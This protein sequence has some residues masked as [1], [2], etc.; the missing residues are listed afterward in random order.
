[1]NKLKSILLG[2]LAIL[3]YF[4]FNKF[5]ALP[6]VIFN[7]DVNQLPDIIK[8]IYS[9]IIDLLIIIV[10]YTLFKDTINNNLKDIKKNHLTYFKTYIKYWF[11]ALGLMMFSN[12]IIMI[13]TDSNIAN[14]EQSIRTLFKEDPIFI[15]IQAVI[16]APIIEE[17][18]FRQAF[19]NIFSNNIIFIL[20]SGI[21]FGSMHVFTSYNSL[22]DLL[23]IIPYSIPGII[24]AYTLVKSKNI[25][26]PMGLH[27]IHNG[28]LLSL[29]FVTLIFGW[30]KWKRKFLFIF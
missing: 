1:M 9:I 14:N 21:V 27:F 6:F 20:A 11:I 16:L 23:Y 22:T 28:L 5:A 19:R 25:F 24:F 2:V 18:V 13:F 3:T 7:I 4:I 17:L 15:F 29:Q 12:L 26:V 10:I 30:F 8:H